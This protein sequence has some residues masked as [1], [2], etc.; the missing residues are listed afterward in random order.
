MQPFLLSFIDVNLRRLIGESRFDSES[1]VVLSS[2]FFSNAIL[3]V[4]LGVEALAPVLI[5]ADRLLSGDI[6]EDVVVLDM[7]SCLKGD[8]PFVSS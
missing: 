1:L 7:V 6:D 4:P 8:L 3:A 5:D 2:S